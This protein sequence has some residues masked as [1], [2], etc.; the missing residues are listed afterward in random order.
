[1]RP[2]RFGS[3]KPDLRVK[4]EF[5]ELT[6]VMKDVDF[7]VFSGAANMKNGRVV[8]LRARRR[9]EM[10]GPRGEIDGYTEFVKIYG[11]KGWPGSRSMSWRRGATV[12]SRPS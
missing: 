5:T 11:A 7:K 6:D 8:A 4:L 9:R 2:Y 3:D 12:C 1:M 10:S